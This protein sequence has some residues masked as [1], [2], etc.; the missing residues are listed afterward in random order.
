MVK[1][2]WVPPKGH[3]QTF[4]HKLRYTFRR[5]DEPR[6]RERAVHALSNDDRLHEAGLGLGHHGGVYPW[7]QGRG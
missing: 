1:E 4:R 2:R 7:K 6:K 5:L 3:K